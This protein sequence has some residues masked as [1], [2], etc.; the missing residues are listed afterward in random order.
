[1]AR[2][3]PT[4][5]RLKPVMDDPNASGNA[6]M[7][8]VL[9]LLYYLKGEAKHLDQARKTLL[10]VGGVT[11]TPALQMA[12]LFNAAETLDA[13]L[14]I[15]LV[16][17]R[18]DKATDALFGRVMGTSLPNRAL[19]VIKAG[20]VLPEGHPARYKE[21]IDGKATAYVCRGAIC[22]LPVTDT[23]DLTETLLLMR[24]GGKF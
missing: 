1:M 23:K 8:E 19:E 6:K 7:A 21:Q 13:A 18:G 20:T 3:G 10:A 4:M 22:S 15:V 16:G 9:A 5:A 24:K 17:N 11:K 2:A 14:Q 12:G